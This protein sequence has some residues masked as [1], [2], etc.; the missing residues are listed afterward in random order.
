[1]IKLKLSFW[2][3]GPQLSK[4]ERATQRFWERVEGWLYWPV[5]QLDPETCIP[6]VLDLLA[7]QKGVA[8]FDGESMRLY[9]LRVKYAFVNA[10]DA[11][12]VAGLKR[13]FERL[14]IGYVEIEERLPDRDWD[15]IKLHLS[16]QQMADNPELLQIILRK[17]GRLCRR[18]EFEVLTPL[19][20]Q[21]RTAD[22]GHDNGFLKAS[23]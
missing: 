18:Y 4:L 16:D 14:L 15:V 8:R 2:L 11:G 6:G 7:W 22:C 1:M 3:G 17:Y 10:Q 20:V 9:R 19:Q 13:I 21:L 23:L 5:R 12:S